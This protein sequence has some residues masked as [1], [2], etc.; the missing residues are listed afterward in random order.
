MSISIVVWKVAL[1]NWMSMIKGEFPIQYKNVIL[2]KQ[3][4]CNQLPLEN[5]LRSWN[6]HQLFIFRSRAHPMEVSLRLFYPK[7]STDNHGFKQFILP[8][9]GRKL[10]DQSGKFLPTLCLPFCRRWNQTERKQFKGENRPSKA[11]L[12]VSMAMTAKFLVD[13]SIRIFSGSTYCCT[14][15]NL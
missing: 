14:R 5:W 10:P 3:T 7:F 8:K 13:C 2:I 9:D 15:N 12:T 11:Y 1:K 6:Y 4:T